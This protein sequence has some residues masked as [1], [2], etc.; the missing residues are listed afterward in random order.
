MSSSNK[1]SAEDAKEDP[2]DD[3]KEDG[4]DDSSRMIVEPNGSTIEKFR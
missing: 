3:S 1:H 4:K 2:K